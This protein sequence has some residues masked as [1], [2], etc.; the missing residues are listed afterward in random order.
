LA[1]EIVKAIEQAHNRTPELEMEELTPMQRDVLVVVV[2][3]NQRRYW[4]KLNW[5][6]LSRPNLPQ[7]LGYA[8]FD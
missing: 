2:E 5:S 7:N 6:T 1:E 8:T 3:G 4:E